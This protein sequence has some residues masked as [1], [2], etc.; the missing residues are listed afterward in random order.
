M[1]QR[2]SYARRQPKYENAAFLKGNN[3]IQ[4]FKKKKKVL[5]FFSSR[6]TNISA[7]LKFFSSQKDS[8]SK[9]EIG[10]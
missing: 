9:N 5:K 7:I 8:P 4:I 3:I 10:L 2:E 1:Q 6:N